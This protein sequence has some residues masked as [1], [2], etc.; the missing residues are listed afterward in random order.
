MDDTLKADLQAVANKDA[1]SFTVTTTL[2]PVPV[3]PVTETVEFS[4]Q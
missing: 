4:P 3:E 1:V 2:P